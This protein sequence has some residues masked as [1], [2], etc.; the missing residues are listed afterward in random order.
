MT[1]Y[2]LCRAF[3]SNVQREMSAWR[4]DVALQRF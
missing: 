2:L 1:M 4:L 3:N